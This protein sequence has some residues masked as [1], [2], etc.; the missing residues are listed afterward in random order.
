MSIRI[1]L[2][3]SA[4]LRSF[5]SN[6]IRRSWNEGAE[7]PC[8]SDGG[9]IMF[10]DQASIYVKAGRGGNGVVSFRR[11]KFIPKGGPDGGNGGRGGSVIIRADRQLTTLMDFRYKRSYRAESGQPGEAANRTGKSGDD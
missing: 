11:E 9:Q 6:I 4:S 7:Q 3:Q 2:K 1:P 8:G 5:S 10:I